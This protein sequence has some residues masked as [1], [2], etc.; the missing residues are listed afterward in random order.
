MVEGS[1]RSVVVVG[2]GVGGLAAAWE[3]RQ[4]GKRLGLPLDIKVMEASARVGGSVVTERVEGCIVEGGPDCILSEK[5]GGLGLIEDLG[6]S[7]H[8]SPTNEASR[9]TYVLSGG[10]LHALPDGLILL[11]PTRIMPFITTRLF[12]WPGKLRM[13]LDLLL[14]RGGDGADETLGDFIRRRLGHEALVKLGEP[15]VA[16]IHSGDPETM[17]LA[18]TFPRF[19]E[20]E[21][22][23]RSLILSMTRRMKKARKIRKQGGGRKAVGGRPHTM[24]VTLDEGMG[25]LVDELVEQIGRENVQTECPV[26][27]LTRGDEGWEVHAADGCV[28]ADAVLLACPAHAAAGITERMAPNL[29]EELRRIPYVSSATVTLAYA[30][31]T[32]PSHVGGFGAVVPGGEPTPLKAFTWATTKFF[33]RAPE[34]TVLMRCFLRAA[35]V[36]EGEGMRDRM[37]DTAAGE[38]R[39]V[40]GVA[41]EPLW[42]RSYFW[43]D[44]MPQYVVGHLQRVELIEQL[45]DGQPGLELA[46][47]AYHGSGIP[48]TVEFSRARARALVAGLRRSDG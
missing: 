47:G 20:M 46:G 30:E 24:F 36:V 10:Q 4:E 42:G 40:L 28:Q 18:A 41:A 14:P 32:F 13:G 27:N 1:R 11:V 23:D 9:K 48:D 38:L 25:L 22:E 19:R 21:K 43:E 16:G 44:A 17:S 12:S 37:V 34:G 6:L 39:R 7:A 15:L 3:L 2:A 8:L 5:P 33:G 29:A 45:V 31:N 35:D 26:S